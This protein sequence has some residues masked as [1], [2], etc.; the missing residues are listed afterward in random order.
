LELVRY[1][2]DKGPRAVRLKDNA[3]RLPLHVA[4]LGTSV[5]TVE[6]LAA[7][8]LQ[9]LLEPDRRGRL[10][11][12]LAVHSKGAAVQVVRCLAE[13]CPRA[14]AV[15]VKNSEFGMPLLHW[16]VQLHPVEIL[17]I[18]VAAAAGGGGGGGEALLQRDDEGQVPL[19][20]AVDVYDAAAKVQCLVRAGPLARRERNHQGDLPLHMAI[21]SNEVGSNEARPNEAARIMVDAWDHALQERD[22]DGMLPLHLAVRRTPV[23]LVRILA[24]R[25]EPALRGKDD[26]GQLPLH[27]AVMFAAPVVDKCPESVRARDNDGQLPLHFLPKGGCRPC[28]KG[29]TQGASRCITR[30]STKRRH[31]WSGTLSTRVA[32]QKRTADGYLPLHWAVRWKAPAKVVQ[33]LVDKY[34]GA[35]SERTD[36]GLLPLHV[37]AQR[38]RSV[39]FISSFCSPR[40]RGPCKERRRKDFMLCTLLLGPTQTWMSSTSS[41]GPWPQ[42]VRPRLRTPGKKRDHRS[43]FRGFLRLTV[44]WIRGSVLSTESSDHR[45]N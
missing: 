11:L 26:H 3:G 40:L 24:D 35:L 22:G 42:V 5:P 6:I 38:H 32:M 9:G 17:Q 25:W 37:A 29:T 14:V 1:L 31:R 44:E 23:G 19:H 39:E 7:A 2:V 13:K 20:V 15:P 30:S 4:A 33:I 28:S 18:L 36:D 16:A 43:A 21:K 41:R 45:R 34:R 8:S 12:H 27:H 10:P